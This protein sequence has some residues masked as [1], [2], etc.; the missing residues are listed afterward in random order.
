MGGPWCT[1]A[2][3][4]KAATALRGPGGAHTSGGG[5]DPNA[6]ENPNSSEDAL[7]RRLRADVPQADGGERYNCQVAAVD[8]RELHGAAEDRGAG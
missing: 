3:H 1:P 5:E 7:P 8:G 2:T 4:A 6:Q